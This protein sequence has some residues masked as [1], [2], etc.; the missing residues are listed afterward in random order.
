M[1]AKAVII[2]MLVPV[3][4]RPEEWGLAGGVVVV[5]V[6]WSWE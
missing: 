1:A 4:V 2:K 6:A 5:E 3:F